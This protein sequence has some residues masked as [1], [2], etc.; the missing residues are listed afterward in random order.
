MIRPGNA[1]K[2]LHGG[3]E[4]E[5]E[6]RVRETWV[7]GDPH[8]GADR[9]ADRALLDLLDR[10]AERQ[11]ELVVMGDL[12]VAWIAIERFHT[13]VQR[14]VL[15]KMR[16]IRAR[17]GTVRFVVG[18]RD[19][20][21]ERMI[22]TAFDTVHDD[23]TVLDLA[24]VPTM[25]VHGDRLN[26]RDRSYLVW[27]RFS[28][29]APLA[30]AVTRLPSAIGRRLAGSIE[31]RMRDLN[32]AYKTGAL[33]RDGIAA[34][35]ERAKAAGARRAIVGHFHAPQTIE[36]AVPVLVAPGWFEHRE[37]LDLTSCTTIDRK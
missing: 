30:A 34:L 29:S 7:L 16:A 21:A 11:V 27:R 24:G 3:S 28:R 23:E 12:F 22:G 9:E 17:G 13:P 4:R 19:Y 26:A 25:V 14:E 15:E 31:R 1:G 33:P 2:V 20:L 6:D 18:N 5:N 32:R 8:A 10:A 35:A 36:A 37:V